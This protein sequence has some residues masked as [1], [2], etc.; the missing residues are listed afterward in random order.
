ME[1]QVPQCSV[2]VRKKRQ[3]RG[4]K[5]SSSVKTGRIVAHENLHVSDLKIGKQTVHCLRLESGNL[6]GIL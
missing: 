2:S 4:S 3:K 1:K 6:L 5:E